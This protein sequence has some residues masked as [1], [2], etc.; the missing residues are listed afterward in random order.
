MKN[1]SD[2]SALEVLDSVREELDGSGSAAL[3]KR[4]LA[5][6]IPAFI[7]LNEKYFRDKGFSTAEIGTPVNEAPKASE[8]R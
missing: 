2:R 7:A 5:W 4:D 6:L 3:T 8:S 1:L